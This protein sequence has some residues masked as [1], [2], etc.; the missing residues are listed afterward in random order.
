[1]ITK[2]QISIG[3]SKINVV[4]PAGKF[5]NYLAETLLIDGIIEPVNECQKKDDDNMR[6]TPKQKLM[7][8]INKFDANFLDLFV[9]W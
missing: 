6:E 3:G 4:H 8:L 5:N 2:N 7:Q 9:K 1:M